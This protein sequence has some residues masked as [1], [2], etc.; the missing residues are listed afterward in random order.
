MQSNARKKFV[1]NPL[2][3]NTTGEI[4]KGVVEVSIRARQECQICQ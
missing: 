4:G 2:S 3:V 1:A